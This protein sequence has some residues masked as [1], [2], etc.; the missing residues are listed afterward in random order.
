MFSGGLLDGK[1]IVTGIVSCDTSISQPPT[2]TPT[3]LTA[4]SVIR[5]K[6][7]RCTTALGSKPTMRPTNRM[8]KMF[9][10]EKYIGL[11]PVR[12]ENDCALA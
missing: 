5:P 10:P 9:S 1:S 3:M 7:V 4:M 6:R 2:K 12:L 11:G 8:M